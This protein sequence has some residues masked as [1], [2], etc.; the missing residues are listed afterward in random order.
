MIDRAI[1]EMGALIPDAGTLMQYFYGI[2][3]CALIAFSFQTAAQKFGKEMMVAIPMALV[4][5]RDEEQVALLQLLEHFL[6]IGA[7]SDRIAERS[8]E[9]V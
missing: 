3:Q 5:Q 2:S 6:T 1:Q 7:F 4:V 8:T 9:L